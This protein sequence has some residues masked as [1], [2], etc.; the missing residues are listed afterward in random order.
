MLEAGLN[1]GIGFRASKA[2]WL[3]DDILAHIG[4]QQSGMYWNSVWL[5][6]TATGSLK[7]IA[8]DRFGNKQ[9]RTA[10]NILNGPTWG[11]DS[12]HTICIGTVDGV[13]TMYV[14]GAEIGNVTGTALI[15]SY[16]PYLTVND[17]PFPKSKTVHRFAEARSLAEVIRLLGF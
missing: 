17:S 2:N 16:P 10:T 5:E 15:Y 4:M 1:K 9:I 12:V 13:L 6:S 3:E 7:L 11:S 14:D 8:L